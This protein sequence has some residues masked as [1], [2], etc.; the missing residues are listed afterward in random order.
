M[1]K[2][3]V[4]YR[5]FFLHVIRGTLT[6]NRKRLTPG[7]VML[8][9]G[10]PVFFSSTTRAVEWIPVI[11]IGRLDYVRREAVERIVPTRVKKPTKA[12][13]ANRKKLLHRRRVKKTAIS[14]HP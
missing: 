13:I 8:A 10:E 11:H 7:R 2:R 4:R 1:A 12:Q 6:K 9:V 14:S 5:G 3:P